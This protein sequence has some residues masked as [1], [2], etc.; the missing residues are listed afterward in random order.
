MAALASPRRPAQPTRRHQPPLDRHIAERVGHK[1]SARTAVGC[2]AC[3][4]VLDL[5]PLCQGAQRPGV[6]QRR[7]VRV[8]TGCRP[9]G[10]VHHVAACGC[11]A[12]LCEP[13]LRQA[14]AGVCAAPVEAQCQ[15][16]ALIQGALEEGIDP[17]GWSSLGD[18]VLGSLV[19]HIACEV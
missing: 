18:A 2:R 8:S 14:Q 11:P 3:E 17:C 7:R 4:V 16:V 10:G 19:Q 9:L 12:G 6:G 1:H 5:T 15:Q 13:H